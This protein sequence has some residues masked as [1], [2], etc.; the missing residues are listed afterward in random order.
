MNQNDSRQ[1]NYTT[2]KVDIDKDADVDV[3]VLVVGAGPTGL[4]MAAEALRLGLTCHIIESKSS[5]MMNHSFMPW[6]VQ[7]KEVGLPNSY[8]K[9]EQSLQNSEDWM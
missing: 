3:D 6:E 4:A 7:M 8:V 5:R 1:G 2:K 9:Q